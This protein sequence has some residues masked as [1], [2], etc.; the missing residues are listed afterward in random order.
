MRFQNEINQINTKDMETVKDIEKK[1]LVKDIEAVMAELETEA[2]D[3]MRDMEDRF[4]SGA[5]Y[6]RSIDRMGVARFQIG[7]LRVI[8]ERI[9]DM[10]IKRAVL[11]IRY[12]SH[13]LKSSSS[14]GDLTAKSCGPLSEKLEQLADRADERRKMEIYGYEAAEAV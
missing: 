8:A 13:S 3:A 2:K 1:E 7:F 11:L 9:E 14:G 10:D 5:E 4:Y 12:N 6:G